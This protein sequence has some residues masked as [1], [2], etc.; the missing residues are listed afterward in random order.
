MQHLKKNLFAPHLQSKGFGGN[1]IFIGGQ[2]GVASFNL[3]FKHAT[4]DINYANGG[5]GESTA[6]IH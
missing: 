1:R 5:S 4:R 6:E 3:G 2:E